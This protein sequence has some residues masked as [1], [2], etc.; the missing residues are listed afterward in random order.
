MQGT[1]VLYPSPGMGHI[2]SMVELGKLILHHYNNHF[3]ITILLIN[4]EFSSSPTIISY[5]DTISKTYPSISFHPLTPHSIDI[6]PPRSYLAMA[7]ELIRVSTLEAIQSLAEISKRSKVSAFIIDY[8]CTYALSEAKDL[9]IPT[10]YFSTSG[11]GVLATFL[12]FPKICKQHTKSF[13]DLPDTVFHFPGGLPD[14]R[15]INM[16]DPLLDRDDPAYLEMVYFSSH[17][18]KAD[19][20]IVNTFDDLEPKA[21]RLLTD[22]EWARDVKVPPIYPIGPLIADGGDFH[23]ECLS[24][25]DRQP[26]KSVVFMCFGSRG[27]FSKKQVKEIAKGLEM[28][29]QRF[30]WVVK[31]PPL[32]EVSKQTD[33]TNEFDLEETMPQGFLERIQDR[34]KVVKSWVPQMK[35]LSHESVGGF[36]T[37]C[38]W[39]SVLEAVVAGVPLVAWPLYAEQHLNRNLL[40]EYMEMAIPVDQSDEDGFVSG[41]EVEKRVRELMESEKGRQLKEKS[42]K[43][44][45][46]AFAAWG[47]ESGS[48]LRAFDVLVKKWQAANSVGVAYSPDKEKQSN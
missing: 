37:H 2:V 44:K 17:M 26:S 48:S 43:L 1:I 11:A 10:Y 30:L 8:F 21:V 18:P 25:L 39:N 41:D 46:S 15:A 14:L 5:V 6:F 4:G 19:G 22:E 24:W 34:G 7:F 28:S 23:H 31:K 38:G 40:V 45:E 13:K 32:D 27:S 29:G 47:D 35:V 36:M 9:N 12:N 42:R 33:H 20:I 16:P 3:S